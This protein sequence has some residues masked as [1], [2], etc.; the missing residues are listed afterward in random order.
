[1]K[2]VAGEKDEDLIMRM[3]W[4]KKKYVYKKKNSCEI[5]RKICGPIFMN[6]N[7]IQM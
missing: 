6:K 2:K 4:I 7:N 3:E 1:M 5:M